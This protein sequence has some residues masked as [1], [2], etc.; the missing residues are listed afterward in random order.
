[1]HA[2]SSA[3]NAP[4]PRHTSA[5]VWKRARSI[6]GGTAKVTLTFSP[7]ALNIPRVGI[8]PPIA[9]K[10]KP[11]TTTRLAER[12]FHKGEK[13]L[14]RSARCRALS[15]PLY[16]RNFPPVVPAPLSIVASRSATR[17]HAFRIGAR[18]QEDRAKGR[19][20]FAE[21]S[22]CFS[23]E[24]RSRLVDSSGLFCLLH[25]LDSEAEAGV[26]KNFQ[27]SLFNVMIY[28][29]NNEIVLLSVL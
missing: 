14:Y 28:L 3:T 2:H 17:D 11:T 4:S 13:E 15:S 24:C 5:R 25:F 12:N 19:G 26:S 20:W 18:K 6:D 16:R 22:P 21:Q 9:N 10:K 23:Y 7:T 27:I 29:Q 8:T 1:M